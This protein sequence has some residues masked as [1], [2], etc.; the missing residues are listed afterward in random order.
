MYKNV[1]VTVM[2]AASLMASTAW[3][4]DIGKGDLPAV[5]AIN[6]KIELSA[7]WGDIDP[8]DPTAVFQGGASLS[9]PVGDRFGLQADI[10]ALN[11]FGDTYR[12]A[13]LH[14]FTR[15]PESY[16]FGVA[17]GI[18]SANAATFQYIGPEAE[19]YADRVSIEA[20]AGYMNLDL[21]GVQSSQFFGFGDIAY[22]ADDNLRLSVG[23]STVAGFKSGHINGEWQ[24]SDSG[25][26]LS[27]TAEG[28]VG[29]AGLVTASLGLKLYFGAQDKTLIR[30]HREDDPRNRTLD[31]FS[32]AGSAFKPPAGGIP[33]D[34][35]AAG[36]IK[37]E[38]AIGECVR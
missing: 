28:R 20:W 4:A 2:F 36:A 1:F 17:G 31:I 15:N 10:A 35:C 6:G 8:V 30:R 22:Y 16:L 11:Q 24:I 9:I 25:L 12:G 13:A 33:I 21:A 18:G 14:A 27:L 38:V 32:A 34:P 37:A 23:A 5:S 29:D 7:G 26:P 3:S 19:F